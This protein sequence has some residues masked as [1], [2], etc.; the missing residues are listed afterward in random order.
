MAQRLPNACNQL[1]PALQRVVQRFPITNDGDTLIDVLMDIAWPDDP[2]ACPE[3]EPALSKAEGPVLSKAE[4]PVLSK[5]EGGR[6]VKPFHRQKAGKMLLERGAGKDPT[7]VLRAIRERPEP[8][9]SVSHHPEY[10]PDYILDPTKSCIYCSPSLGMKE[11][12]EGD[13]RRDYEAL[14]KA[15]AEVQRMKD[16]LG[17]KPDPNRPKIDISSYLPPKD[18]VPHPDQVRKEAAKFWADIELRLERQKQ[19][20]AIEERRRKKLA[21]IYPS[22][23]DDEPSRSNP[24]D[25]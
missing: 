4:G 24:P 3:R 23:S 21:Q 9:Q 10:P 18:W 2:D 25:P 20:P 14:A 13:H 11:G 15:R 1:S 22:H 16:E 12:H 17:I 5:A 8:S 6:K 19:W 7:P